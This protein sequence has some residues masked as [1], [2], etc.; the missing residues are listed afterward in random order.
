MNLKV[1][2]IAPEFELQGVIGEKRT[3][4]N[5]AEQRGKLNIVLAFYPVDW[6]PV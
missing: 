5:L 3:R 1:G 2:D 4:F 6:S